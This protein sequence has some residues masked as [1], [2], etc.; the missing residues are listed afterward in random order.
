VI[1][2]PVT[3]LVLII[4]GLVRRAKRRKREKAKETE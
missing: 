3:I 2:I 1:V 4:R